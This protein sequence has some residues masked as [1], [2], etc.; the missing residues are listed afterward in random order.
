[1]K[2]DR[3]VAFIMQVFLQN[4]YPNKAMDDGSDPVCLQNCTLES[5]G[6]LYKNPL[7]LHS[8]LLD[9]PSEL[10]IL[11]DSVEVDDTSIFVNA[12]DIKLSIL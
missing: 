9:G 10:C 8:L 11:E 2:I 6:Q 3:E 1:M 4:F 5:I 12:F 7:L